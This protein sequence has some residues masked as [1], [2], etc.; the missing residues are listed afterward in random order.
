MA[1]GS[2]CVCS[3]ALE[4]VYLFRDVSEAN[5]VLLVEVERLELPSQLE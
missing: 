3:L 5:V 1:H 4:L 2:M